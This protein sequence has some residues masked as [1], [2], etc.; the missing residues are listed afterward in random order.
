MANLVTW[1]EFG[2]Q[3]GARPQGETIKETVLAEVTN[4]ISK[5]RPLLSMI[6]SRSVTNTYVE[7]L[8]DELGDNPFP[9]FESCVD[10]VSANSEIQEILEKQR[11]R[12]ELALLTYL[13]IET[14]H[15]NFRQWA[16]RTGK[17]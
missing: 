5:E 6:G 1:D 7:Q 13:T 8:T 15:L 10:Y 2:E 17:R 16:K 12:W 14:I 11:P 3:A 9:N 4:L